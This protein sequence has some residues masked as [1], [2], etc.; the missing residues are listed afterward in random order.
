MAERSCGPA[1]WFVL[2]PR[3]PQVKQVICVNSASINGYG[4]KPIDTF[5]VGWTSIYQLFWCS[6]GTRVLTHPQITYIKSTSLLVKKHHFSI[7]KSCICHVFHWK[8]P[9]HSGFRD[10]PSG[11]DQ[12]ELAGPVPE[13]SGHILAPWRLDSGPVPSRFAMGTIG[14]LWETIGKPWA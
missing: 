13:G 9:M 12:V 1:R 14:K 7:W 4:S 2:F 3:N 10:P 11:P 5:L 8:N 6:L